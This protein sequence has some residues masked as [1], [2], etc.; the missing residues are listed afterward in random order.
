[1][2]SW[3]LLKMNYSPEII[4]VKFEH[5]SAS[6]IWIGNSHNFSHNYM[7]D[8]TMFLKMFSGNQF[9]MCGPS[10]LK[11]LSPNFTVFQ[12]WTLRHPFLWFRFGEQWSI[13]SK[14]LDLAHLKGFKLKIE[15]RWPSTEAD[16]EPWSTSEKLLEQL[17]NPTWGGEGLA[18]SCPQNFYW[19]I[20]LV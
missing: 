5:C 11:I 20:E 7:K 17:F 15:Y 1:M 9:H 19:L 12:K 10:D 4:T 13:F 2:A 6:W 18:D 8:M 3:Y 14:S 16:P